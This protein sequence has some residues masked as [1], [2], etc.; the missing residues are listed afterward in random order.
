MCQGNWLLTQ[1]I[2]EFKAMDL[3]FSPVN[4]ATL[5]FSQINITQT[6]ISQ[7]GIVYSANKGWSVGPKVIASGRVDI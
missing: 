6:D 1:S 5:M 3:P 7:S 4:N 2:Q